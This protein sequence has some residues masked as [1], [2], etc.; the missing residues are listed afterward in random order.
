MISDQLASQIIGDLLWQKLIVQ[1]HA[2]R[3]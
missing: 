1:I 3:E 2:R